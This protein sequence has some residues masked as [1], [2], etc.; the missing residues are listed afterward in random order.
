MLPK[1]AMPAIVTVAPRPIQLSRIL[2]EVRGGHTGQTRRGGLFKNREAV[3]ALPGVGHVP[4]RLSGRAAPGW[5]PCSRGDSKIAEPRRE[6]RRPRRT[7]R[8]QVR[9]YL[10]VTRKGMDANLH[11]HCP[12]HA[13]RSSGTRAVFR[14]TMGGCVSRV[15]YGRYILSERGALVSGLLG[16]A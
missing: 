15:A 14:C 6:R 1:S 7:A 3:A 2:S 11:V 9:A 13:G 4:P 16:P 10:N 5:S 12:G 8:E